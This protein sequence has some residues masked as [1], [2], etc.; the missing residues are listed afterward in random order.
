MADPQ[1][2]IPTDCPRSLVG[3]LRFVPLLCAGKTLHAIAVVPVPASV[4]GTRQTN[5]LV[6]SGNHRAAAAY[7]CK[8]AIV[9]DVIESDVDLAHVREGVAAGYRSVDDL[10]AACLEAAESGGYLSGRWE[11]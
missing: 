8:M 9:A 10:V 6:C 1:Y 11:E 5:Y 4:S 3:V 7:I 2:L